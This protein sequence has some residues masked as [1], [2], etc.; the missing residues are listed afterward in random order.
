[1]IKR[2]LYLLSAVLLV[3]G[4]GVLRLPLGADE[5]DAAALGHGIADR[6]QSAMQHRHRL[7]QV[8]DVNVVAGAENVLGHLRVPSMGLMAEVNASFQ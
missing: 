2:F 4:N 8:D 3:F 1:M 5:Q 7:G 6:L